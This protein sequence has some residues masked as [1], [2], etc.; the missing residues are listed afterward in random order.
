MQGSIVRKAPL[1]WLLGG[2]LL[3]LLQVAAVGIKKPL[4]VSTQFV[5]A[6]TQILEEVAPA[7]VEGHKLIDS[8]KYRQPGYGW[9]LAL[10]I[11]VGALG[12]ALAS[13]RWRLD[14]VPVWWKANHGP[15]AGKRFL[16]A[17]IGGFFVLLGARF[18]HGCTSGQ[19]ASGWAQLSVSA[20]PFTVALFGVAM[21]VARFVYPKTPAIEE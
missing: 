21:L 8:K 12:A 9:W 14:A 19:F 16:W 11:P 17:V 2:L 7:Y 15:K 6:D 3:G 4:G 13:R 10:G 18:A 20:I 1:G 5:V